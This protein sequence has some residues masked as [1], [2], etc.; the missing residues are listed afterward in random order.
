[1]LKLTSLPWIVLVASLISLSAYAQP[2]VDLENTHSLTKTEATSLTKEQTKQNNE[3]GDPITAVLP[4][5]DRPGTD[6]IELLQLKQVREELKITDEQLAKIKEIDQ[7]FRAEIKQT[8]SGVNLE[9]LDPQEE[10]EKI[11]ELLVEMKTATDKVRTELGEVLQPEQL[12]RF[13][14]IILQIYG[15]GVLTYDDFAESLGITQQQLEQLDILRDDMVQEMRDT[16]QVPDADTAEERK[17]ILSANNQKMQAILTSYNDKATAVL[18][19]EQKK[20]LET[21]KGEQF[22]LDRQQLPPEQ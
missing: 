20:N 19:E 10:D 6:P 13:R 22:Q 14:E 15:W 16:W 4:G 12:D 8:V 1:M 5:G 7:N 9:E 3:S 17:K 11:S 21:L 2:K 18:T